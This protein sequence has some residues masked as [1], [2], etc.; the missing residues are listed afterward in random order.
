VQIAPD[1][2]VA[3]A[4]LVGHK[5]LMVETLGSRALILPKGKIDFGETPRD[6]AERELAEEGALVRTSYF[7]PEPIARYLHERPRSGKLEVHDVFLALA[8]PKHFDPARDPEG[9]S[10][11]LLSLD[12]ALEAI[13]ADVADGRRS[14]RSGAEL[15]EALHCAFAVARA[16]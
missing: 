7:S 2:R 1:I 15:A 13:V 4:A 11:R 6:A 14:A 8:S 3:T 12:Q 9:R 10:P 16:L 5:L